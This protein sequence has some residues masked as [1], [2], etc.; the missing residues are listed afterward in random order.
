MAYDPTPTEWL[1]LFVFLA[2]GAISAASFYGS[3]MA[4]GWR[5]WWRSMSRAAR[6]PTQP[7]LFCTTH[8]V[9]QMMVGVGVWLFWRDAVRGVD[10]ELS[11]FF[12]CMIVYLVYFLISTSAGA[13]LF[14]VGV[15]MGWMSAA[16]FVAVASL[17]L[18]VALTSMMFAVESI[19][20]AVV[21]LIPA[22]WA[23]Y[24]LVLAIMMHHASRHRRHG[25]PVH[26][27]PMQ[28]IEAQL[29]SLRARLEEPYGAEAAA[30][31]PMRERRGDRW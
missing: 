22:V 2:L 15:Q 26:H 3:A 14:C 13:A 5:L 31:V 28:H 18:L 27:D 24:E 9:M 12:A 25:V 20:A 7:A 23:V 29:Q 30:A 16:V 6:P 10:G 8:S 4:I 21:V 19:A 1:S 17:G 11:T